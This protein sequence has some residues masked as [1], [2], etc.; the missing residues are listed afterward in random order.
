MLM[1]GT[2]MATSIFAISV[3]TCYVGYAYGYKKGR[4][5]VVNKL[6]HMYYDNSYNYDRPIVQEHHHGEY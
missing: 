5:D 1:E 6:R 2:I 3:F 4:D